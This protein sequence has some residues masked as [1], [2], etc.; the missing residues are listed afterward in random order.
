MS[1]LVK[2]YSS[3]R[4]KSRATAIPGLAKVP[5]GPWPWFYVF[6]CWRPSWPKSQH[7]SRRWSQWWGRSPRQATVP[8]HTRNLKV[9]EDTDGKGCIP[10]DYYG[11]APCPVVDSSSSSRL[12]QRPSTGNTS[13]GKPQIWELVDLVKKK[14]R[15]MKLLK[16][17]SFWGSVVSM[18]HINLPQ[19][20][21]FQPLKFLRTSLRD[22]R[23]R[24]KRYGAGQRRGRRT[25]YGFYFIFCRKMGKKTVNS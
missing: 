6:K 19:S 9:A 24:R 22:R 4:R 15:A 12:A 20:D 11:M 7:A 10:L 5:P 2:S 16:K 23:R 25:S 21:I 1:I 13:N 17:K 18:F 3:P 8:S 14:K